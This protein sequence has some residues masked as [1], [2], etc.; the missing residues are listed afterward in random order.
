MNSTTSCEG[1]YEDGVYFQYGTLD[2]HLPDYEGMRM[3]WIKTESQL[4]VNLDHC[5]D[6]DWRPSTE[7]NRFDIIATTS[8]DQTIYLATG[9]VAVNRNL[10]MGYIEEFISSPT[11]KLLKLE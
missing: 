9:V 1:G 2:N 4:L 6:I 7:K 5:I 10:F 8:T 11:P 3:K